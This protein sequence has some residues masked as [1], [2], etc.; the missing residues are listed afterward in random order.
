MEIE[1]QEL[2]DKLIDKGWKPR[3]IYTSLI[4]W[5]WLV[6][7]EEFV[8]SPRNERK[9]YRELVSKESWLR[10]FCCETKLIEQ[11]KTV[12]DYVI[13]HITYSYDKGCW[14]YAPNNSEFWIMMSALCD[15][16]KLE[17]FILSNIK[18]NE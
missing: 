14:W 15:E 1:L 6:R 2:I 10:Q 13:S 18:I 16:D 3:W 7:C 8:W 11:W 4:V 9:S 12:H 17:D 5:Y